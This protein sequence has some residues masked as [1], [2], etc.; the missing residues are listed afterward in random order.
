MIIPIAAAPFSN[1]AARAEKKT[2]QR[3]QTKQ[4]LQFHID[5]P[6]Q[7]LDLKQMSNNG[8]NCGGNVRTTRYGR[9][10]LLRL[11]HELSS[12]DYDYEQD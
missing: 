7:N 10:L 5:P 1:D 2:D 9:R 4:D 11:T 6:T 12:E 8:V 3:Q